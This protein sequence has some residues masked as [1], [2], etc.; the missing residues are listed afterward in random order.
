MIIKLTQIKDGTHFFDGKDDLETVGLDKE[1]C[2]DYVST[3]VTVDKRG[4]NYYIKILSHVMGKFSCDRCLEM[5]EKEIISES[6]IIYTED[7]TLID[8]MENKNE[9]RYLK[10]SEANVDLSEDIRQFI[11]LAVP[12]KMLC[13]DECKGL[14][15]NCGKNLNVKKC[16]CKTDLKDP[17]WQK[18]KSLK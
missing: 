17:R 15:P 5:F 9:I 16:E 8:S 6:K 1:I 10:P 12:V 7:D 14:C 18:L 11:L 13:S 3:K 2:R 4:Q